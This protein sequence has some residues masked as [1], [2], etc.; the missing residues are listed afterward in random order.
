MG[1][2]AL[3]IL[4]CSSVLITLAA[5]VRQSFGLFLPPVTLDLQIGREVFGLAIAI[6]N[7]VTGFA[8]VFAGALADRFGAGRV[9]L[10]GGGIYALGLVVTVLSGGAL[11][12]HVGLGLLVGIGL[13]A[14]TYSVVFGAVGRAL[15][16]EKRTMAFGIVTGAGSFGMFALV[17][18]VQGL[19]S[20]FD[21]RTAMLLCAVIAVL[22]A[23]ISLGLPQKA[24]PAPAGAQSLRQALDEARTHS[25]FLLLIAG[26]FVCGFHVTFVGTH[27]PA[28]LRDRGIS[29]ETSA[30]AFSMIGLF[31]II[32]AIWLGAM[33]GRF[34]Q[35]YVLS[36]IYFAR[37][38][39]FALFLLL[40]I[41]DWSAV[42]FGAA[43]GF[44]WLG[45]V[46]LTS[47]VVA[48]IFGIRYLATLSGIV[49]LSHQ[50]G[51]FL[52]A[53][54]GGLFY[55]ATGSYDAVW[56]MAIA[57]GLM[58]AVIHLPIADQPLARLKAA[59]AA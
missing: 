44:M 19:L 22:V 30:L 20:A 46:P 15:P 10:I 13:G 2:A 18:A 57:L 4:I 51:A 40:P 34:R 6:Q 36:A 12:L 23:L 14:A 48:R 28:F 5:G 31:N 39:A 43:I 37:A 32:G 9:I 21:W 35:K 25:G 16:P 56:M 50:V 38:V 1:R 49:T 47:G 33:G 26:F 7:L 55:D 24:T 52:G 41:T 17:P 11:G 54:L 45:T 59:P 3:V 58:A 8:S 27:F 42:V 29:P 53:W